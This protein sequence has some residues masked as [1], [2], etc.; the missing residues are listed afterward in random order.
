MII[1]L[2]CGVEGCNKKVFACG[3]CG[4][5]YARLKRNGD[6]DKIK[7]KR[8]G[9]S[10]EHPLEYKIW[11]DMNSRCHNKNRE[12][13]MHY[14][15]RGIEVC[16]RWSGIDGFDNFYEDMGDKPRGATLDRIDVNKNY[17]PDNCRWASSSVQN[18]NKRSASVPY[19][20]HDKKGKHKFYVRFKKLFGD[21]NVGFSS[22]EDARIYRDKVLKERNRLDILEAIK[23][24]ESRCL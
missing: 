20:W 3:L 13:Y 19:I 24:K 22:L 7:Y 14:G 18:I 16:E 6:V 23:E 21:D 10:K 9:K 5:H 12:H 11:K 1:A 15:G 8:T 17:S 2:T 4:M